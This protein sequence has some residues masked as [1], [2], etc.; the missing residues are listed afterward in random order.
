[1]THAR[2]Y[3]ISERGFIRTV[4][5]WSAS[6]LARTYC[7][8]PGFF[9]RWNILDDKRTFRDKSWNKRPCGIPKAIAL[10]RDRRDGDRNDARSSKSA[11]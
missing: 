1:M 11:G 2:D 9:Q 3:Y 7:I 10:G 4:S 5:V 6:R 8:D